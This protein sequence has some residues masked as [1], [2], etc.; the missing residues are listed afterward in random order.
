MKKIRVI[1]AD[2]E[3]LARENLRDL[4]APYPE[5]EVV[6]E[7]GTVSEARK[8]LEDLA[9][10]AVFLDIQMPGGTGF[11]V[12]SDLT[13]CLQVIFV[14]A[15]DKFALRAFQ[16]NAIDYLLKPIDRKLLASAVRK[17]TAAH[18]GKGQTALP[19]HTS[20][21]AFRMDDVLISEKGTCFFIPLMTI[22]A[23]QSFRNYTEVKDDQNQTYIFR[24]CIKDWC[25][26]LPSPPFL[27]VD[28]SLMINIEK[29]YKWHYQGR[30]MELEF[31]NVN[32]KIRLGRAATERFRKIISH[33]PKLDAKIV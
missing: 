2:D 15:Y 25:A 33:Y 4:L 7:A 10:D 3:P 23:I 6:G 20:P 5:I 11:D 17:L 21:I 14:T 30:K 24:R 26:K 27:Q 28:R 32:A 8:I 19:L 1:L 16:V 31:K 18:L 13:H 22:C 9:P 12:L 29:I